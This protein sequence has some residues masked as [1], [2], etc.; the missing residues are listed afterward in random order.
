MVLVMRYSNWDYSNEIHPTFF[1]SFLAALLLTRIGLTWF[2]EFLLAWL[3][4][5]STTA[6]GRQVGWYSGDI[7]AC[8]GAPALL[9]SFLLDSTAQLLPLIPLCVC[10]CVCVCHPTFSVGECLPNKL[11][12]QTTRRTLRSSNIQRSSSFVWV[13]IYC[14]V[15]IVENLLRQHDRKMCS[16]PHSLLSF[17]LLITCFSF[18]ACASSLQKFTYLNNSIRVTVSF[19]SVWCMWCVCVVCACDVCACDVCACDVC[20]C[21]CVCVFCLFYV[22]TLL[23]LSHFAFLLFLQLQLSASPHSIPAPSANT[24]VVAVDRGC[25]TRA[26]LHLLYTYL[27]RSGED[28]LT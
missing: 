12:F 10:V 14:S 21:V 26:V 11:C 27:F 15:D 6:E 9:H 20:V 23:Y 1:F 24:A 25:Y 2:S 13:S 7:T 4:S 22:K 5:F 17:L 3:A 16:K 28:A 8:K 19:I 18:V